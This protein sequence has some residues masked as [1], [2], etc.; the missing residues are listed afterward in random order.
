VGLGESSILTIR[1]SVNESWRICNVCKWLAG[2][3]SSISV[4]FDLNKDQSEEQQ[5]RLRLLNYAPILSLHS[6]SGE[7]GFEPHETDK[8]SGAL[9]LFEQSK[10]H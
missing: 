1:S 2:N 10:V 9:S 8:S 4:Y 3:D 5:H 6:K 7:R